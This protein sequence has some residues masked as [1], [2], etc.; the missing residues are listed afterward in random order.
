LTTSPFVSE[1]LI[2]KTWKK[3]GAFEGPGIQKL[4][5]RHQKS[6]KALT[7]FVYSF[8]DDFSEDTCGILLF[9]YHVIAEAF[10][11][12]KP[13]PKRVSKPQIEKVIEDLEAWASRSTTESIKRSPEPFALKYVYEALTEENDVVLSKSE[14]ASIFALHE[15]V[16]ESL[17]RACLR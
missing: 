17:N 14:I 8:L 6:Q 9:I 15:V 3:M 10:E 13:R 1:E 2:E 11:N 16:I 12:A 5:K 7:K 4:Q